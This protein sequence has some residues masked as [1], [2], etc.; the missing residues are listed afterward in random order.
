[1]NY[2]L[3]NFNC[4]IQR[5]Q[6][7]TAYKCMK[8]NGCSLKKLEINHDSKMCEMRHAFYTVF[9]LSTKTDIES[10]QTVSKKSIY[11]KGIRRI[12]YGEDSSLKVCYM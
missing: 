10:A 7:S 5:N 1:M 4:L 8:I 3:H 6:V 2:D 12:R 11:F 9:V